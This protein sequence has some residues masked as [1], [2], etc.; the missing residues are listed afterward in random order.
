M[1]IQVTT[2]HALEH[3]EYREA[4]TIGEELQ[5]IYSLFFFWLNPQGPA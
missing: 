4:D 2:L 1:N 3:G 5:L